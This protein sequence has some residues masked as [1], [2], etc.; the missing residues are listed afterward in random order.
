MAAGDDDKRDIVI[1]NR[2]K[3]DRRQVKQTLMPRVWK[4]KK[5]E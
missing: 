3:K 5:K 1:S 2:W 4:R